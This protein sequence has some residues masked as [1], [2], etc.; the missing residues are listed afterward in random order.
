M[1]G[2]LQLAIMHLIASWAREYKNTPISQK[3]IIAEMGRAGIKDFTVKS[4]L[5]SLLSKGYIR[6]SVITSNKTRYVQL[7]GI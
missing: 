1:I 4:A 3:T 5:K 6:R 7:R 2:G